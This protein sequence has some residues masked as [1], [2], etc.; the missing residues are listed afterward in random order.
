[1]S[2]AWKILVVSVLFSAAQGAWAQE[3]PVPPTEG[4]TGQVQEPVPAYGENNP[5]APPNDN[6]PLSG[7]DLPSLE[8][9]ATPVSYLQAGAT[10]NQSA[11][12]NVGNALG[13]GSFTSVSRALG[14]LT[15]HRLW[16]N[17]DLGLEY[18]GGVGYYSYTGQGFRSLQ[19]MNFDQKVSWKRGQLSVIN[20]FS[21]LPEGTFGGAYGSLGSAGAQSLGS[22]GLGGFWGGNGL[23]ALGLASRITNVS[24][25]AIE[26]SLTP[27][28]AVTATAGYSF[29]H[30]YGNESSGVSFIGSSQVSAQAGYDHTLTS[31]TQVALIYGYQGFDFSVGGTAFHS[32]VVQGLYGHRISG[33]MDLMLGAGPQLTLIDAQT[34]V[35]N[36][37]S[38]PVFLCTLLGGTLG[39]STVRRTSLGVAAQAR[40]R[41]LFSKS[42][43]AMNYERLQ[44][45][46]GGVFAGAQSDIAS[47][48]LSR[49]LTRIWQLV[50][51]MGYTHNDRV[52][53]LTVQQVAQCTSSNFT[54]GSC[55]ANDATSYQT[56]FAG[57]ALHRNFGRSWHA[58]ASYQFN[59]VAFDSSFCITSTAC[60]R[61]SNRQIVTLGLDWTPRPMRLD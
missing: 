55:P 4:T 32:H 13:G 39:E 20:S 27:K 18:V 5:P 6:P 23:A 17:Y 35:C 36:P 57:A 29:T 61:I 44:T 59:E 30:F 41:Y 11:D 16:S 34:A 12:S 15:L 26:Q 2:R 47:V 51:D 3:N 8:P 52:Q 37:P 33:R 45:N 56:G 31:H 50:L 43:L 21:Y 54:Q 49:P 7:L 38:D 22:T 42:S 53:P 9:H 10:L 58:F 40:L 1:M 46:G 48:S 28:S 25:A 60:N 14:T 24:L 19:Q